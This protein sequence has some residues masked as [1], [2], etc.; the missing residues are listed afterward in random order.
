M[1]TPT[2]A[3]QSRAE[4]RFIRMTARKIRLVVD[5][6]RGHMV[7]DAEEMLK[8][9]PKGASV[10]VAK[11]LK[12]AKANATN[13]FDMLEDN[14]FVKT[15]FVNEGPSLKRILPRARGRGDYMVK[16]TSHIIIILEEKQAAVRKPRKGVAAKAVAPAVV[17]VQASAAKPKRAA[18]PKADADTSSEAAAEK[19]KRTRKPKVETTEVTDG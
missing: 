8:F 7:K 1:T 9:I 2:P 10:P 18:K 17:E 12:S 19:P 13:N 15:V 3:L 14:L 11:L 5:A 4:A 16:R 6:I